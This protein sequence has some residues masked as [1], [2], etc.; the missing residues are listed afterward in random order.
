VNTRQPLKEFGEIMF[1][2]GEL[3]DDFLLCIFGLANHMCMLDHDV[4]R[5]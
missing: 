5:S 1:K 3:M 2:E 4:R